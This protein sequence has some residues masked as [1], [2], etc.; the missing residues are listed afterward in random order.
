MIITKITTGVRKLTKCINGGN[1]F[2]AMKRIKQQKPFQRQFESVKTHMFM[3]IWF[4]FVQILS[5]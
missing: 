4:L 1:R 2:N 5:K 3:S